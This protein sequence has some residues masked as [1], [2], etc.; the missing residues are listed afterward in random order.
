MLSYTAQHQGNFEDAVD[1]LHAKTLGP[2]ESWRENVDPEWKINKGIGLS[3]PILRLRR[4]RGG[5][6]QRSTYAGLVT[7]GGRGGANAL[8]ARGGVVG[9][10]AFGRLH[11]C[12]ARESGK[13]ERV[14]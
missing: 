2:A 3:G 7:S 13:R 11:Q 5:A 14:D 1:A 8:L 12:P 4:T 6:V 9:L 10:V